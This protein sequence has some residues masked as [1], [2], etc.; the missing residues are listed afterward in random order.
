MWL[1]Q[2]DRRAPSAQD[3]DMAER[4]KFRLGLVAIIGL[5]VVP[6]AWWW[7]FRCGPATTLLIVR[8]ADR[9][10]NL[11]ALNP[12]GVTRAQEIVH[13]AEKAGIVAIYRS[14]TDRARDTAAPLAAALGIVP[15][16]YP[17]NDTAALVDDIFADHRGEKVLVVG[18]SNTVPQIISG[19]GGPTVPD[20][21]AAEF[22][23]LFVLTACRCRRGL[24]TLVNLQYGAASP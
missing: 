4:W 14:D 24:A 9:L 3:D 11:D 10:D 16:V 1:E 22:D 5:C 18:H 2:A 6:V 21:A 20:I 7:W 17:A 19:A 15:V 23:N 12:A 8:H 13:V